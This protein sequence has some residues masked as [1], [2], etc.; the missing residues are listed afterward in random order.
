MP[1]CSNHDNLNPL[2][3]V[4]IAMATEAAQNGLYARLLG[5]SWL[6]LAEPVRLA[7]ATAAVRCAHGRLRVTRGRG[8]IARVLAAVLRLPRANAAAET[9]LVVSSHGDIEHWRRTFDDR[10]LTTRQYATGDRE[11]GERIGVLEFR[12]RLAP[13]QGSL[14][15]RQVEAAV[16]CG[17]VRVRIPSALAPR[18]EARVDPAGPHQIG[19]QVRVVVPALGPILTYDGIVDLEEQR[20]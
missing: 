12:F 5:S 17:S 10:C 3:T 18:V 6:Q 2:P 7:H 19:I 15:F 4:S 13:S 11:I 16:V 8:Y 1:T 20:E 14:V 9:R